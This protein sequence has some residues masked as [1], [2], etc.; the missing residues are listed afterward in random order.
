MRRNVRLRDWD[1]GKYRSSGFDGKG[2]KGVLTISTRISIV[3]SAKETYG[4]SNAILR[5]EKQ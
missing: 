1:M 5:E 3:R 2:Y 4:G